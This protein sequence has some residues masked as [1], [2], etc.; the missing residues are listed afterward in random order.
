MAAAQQQHLRDRWIDQEV[1]ADR[2]KWWALLVVQLS[3]LLIGIDSTI[4]NLACPTTHLTSPCKL[5]KNQ[6]FL[7][8]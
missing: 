2:Y 4:T 6:S 5:I 3:I 1:A 7:R 8:Y